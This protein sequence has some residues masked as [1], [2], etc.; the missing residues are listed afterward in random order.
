MTLGTQENPAS[1]I[2]GDPKRPLEIG[3]IVIPCYV[4][5]GEVRVVTQTSTRLALG[6]SRTPRAGTGA[7]GGVDK[8]PDFL[9]ANN[10]SQFIGDDLRESTNPVFFKMPETG[11]IAAGYEAELLPLACRVYV[12]A[13]SSGVL[14]ASQEHIALQ[15]DALLAGFA[16]V[17]IIGLIDERTGY[18]EVRDKAALAKILEA[19]I[20]K[21]L[22]PWTF[23]VP[24]EFYEHIFR[25]KGWGRP[26]GIKRPSVIG[27]Y[28]ND[29]VYRRLPVPVLAELREKNPVLPKGYRKN[30]HHRWLT[31]EL[32]HPA[33]REHL[34]GV[35]ALMRASPNWEAFKRNLQR[36]YPRNDETYPMDLGDD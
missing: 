15:C 33:L 17:G 3:D 13:R 1:V 27:H 5:E 23:T 20:A 35:L 16:I 10:L 22:Q 36:A 19:Y 21:D 24:Y 14:Y 30:Q 8:L 11:S 31:P 7:F 4:L 26:D 29:I 9:Q 34:T 12:Q 18:Q 25:F 6:L 2:A 32:G 28:T